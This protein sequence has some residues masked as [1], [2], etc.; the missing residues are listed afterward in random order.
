MRPSLS[1]QRVRRPVGNTPGQCGAEGRAAQHRAVPP[2]TRARPAA[3]AHPPAPAPARLA[4]HP[5]SGVAAPHSPRPHSPPH[6]SSSRSRR[7]RTR[8]PPPHPTAPRCTR[9]R[10]CG[11]RQ[12]QPR[13]PAPSRA[14]PSGTPAGGRGSGGRGG[15]VAGAVGGAGGGPGR[16]APAALRAS[17]CGTSA[18]PR[19]GGPSCTSRKATA[20]GRSRKQHT[21]EG[22]HAAPSRSGRR[23]PQRQAGAAPPGLP[24]GR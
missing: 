8:Q 21:G 20:Y 13:T 22:S 11:P 17:G 3:A 10:C 15:A 4:S 16:A 1:G 12:T 24:L 9:C 5:T 14:T 6:N 7:A 2:S 23:K 18:M 19:S